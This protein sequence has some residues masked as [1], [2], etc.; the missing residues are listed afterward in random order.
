[1][2]LAST[3]LTLLTVYWTSYAAPQGEIEF[4]LDDTIMAKITFQ[5]SFSLDDMILA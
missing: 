1:M 5:I 3:I 4:S 2:K